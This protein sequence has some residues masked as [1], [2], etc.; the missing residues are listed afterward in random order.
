M[1]N[2]TS[3]LQ[4]IDTKGNML[5]T[6][7]GKII[8]QEITKTWTSSGQ[9]MLVDRDGNAIIAVVDRRNYPDPHDDFAE[10]SY[11]LYKV[12]QAGEIL[13][14]GKG[15]DLSFG[16][17]FSLVANMSITQIEDGSYVC[18]WQVVDWSDHCYI[19]MQRVS[20]EGNLLWGEEDGMLN[21]TTVNYE[22]P[23][24]V[25][26]GNNQVILMFTRG[27][28]R[29]LMARKVDFDA[30]KVWAEDLTIYSGGF[31]I[32]PL[33]VILRIIPDQ[34]GGAFVG[35][36]DDRYSILKESTFVSHVTSDGRLGFAS[37]EAGEQV[38]YN[39]YLRGFAPE[40]YF[41]KEEMALYVAWRETSQGQGWQQMTAQKLKIPSGELMWDPNGIEI[42]PLE[43]YSISF[44]SIQGGGNDKVAVFF[45]S[46]TWHPE[47]YYGW[48]INSAILLNKNGEYVWEDKIIEIA[49][50]VS[51]KG[52]L[53]A[54]PLI[55][56]NYWIAAW[57]DERKTADDPYG[58]S[59][60][61]VQR[62]NLD[63]TLGDNG[64]SIPT[65]NL[66]KTS[67]EVFPTMVTNTAEFH[68]MSEKT[69]KA[70]ITLY[71]IMGQKMETIYSGMLNNGEN[72][73]PWNAQK[74]SLSKGIYLAT[75]TIDTGK[76]SLKIIVN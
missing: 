66:P 10:E 72:V 36:Y 27:A 70:E 5:F 50:G 53:T 7:G 47:Y 18:A 37:G 52:S 58:R 39:E 41:N 23:Y 48:D 4:V 69:C 65:N 46:C 9:L 60:V 67:F 15:V 30:S 2:I 25:S 44:Y 35:W 8:S 6:D 11:F 68:I 13:W 22:W 42:A 49:N 33:Y 29:V 21:H 26:A 34:M 56:N 59:K 75:L 32:P 38:G 64:V 1:G 57:K 3:I 74:K 62:I 14:E 54:T 28:G 12:S 51:M 31:T 19:M 61:Y 16:K 71:S 55:N 40:M 63:G 76:K 73:I 17:A 43:E 20:A 45:S 24:L